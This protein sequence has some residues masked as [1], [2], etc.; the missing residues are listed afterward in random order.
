[1]WRDPS[2]IGIGVLLPVILLVLF[3]CGISLDA[4]HLP[5]ATVVDH[6][7]ALTESFL[8]GLRQSPY[9]ALHPCEN[10][11]EAEKEMREGRVQAILWF[12]NH[13][14]KE[15]LSRGY[16]PVTVL[17]NGVDANTARLL[18]GYLDGVWSQWLRQQAITLGKPLRMPV[19]V[20]SRVW[21]N[22]GLESRYHLAP[23]IIAVNM[24]LVGTL[25]T[26][27]VMAREWERGTIEGLFSTPVTRGELL[28]SKI[29]PYYFLGMIGMA[30]SVGLTVSLFGV[31]LEGSLAW[32]FLAATLFLFS[33]LG[34][35]LLISTVSKSTFV[36]S[37]VAIVTAF[38]PAFLLSGFIF[39]IASMPPAVQ[40][41]TYVVAARYFVSLI[42]TLFLAGN[43]WAV[44]WPNLAALLFMA[45]FFLGLVWLF[46]RRSLE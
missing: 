24:T 17:V 1:M 42:Q 45:V 15:A 4:R 13:F 30:L 40:A 39:D 27:L 29:I 14:S 10:L 22:P 19:T 3:G 35:G 7:D 31:P 28:L 21:F 5:L 12:R 23:G 20:E 46:T 25:L 38:L 2:S 16:A 44:L 18:E 33:A 41:V 32:L 6:P 11:A 8:G 43:V 34:L 26:A 36:A 37:M 9:F